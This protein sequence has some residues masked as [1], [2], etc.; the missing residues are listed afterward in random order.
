MR[1][2]GIRLSKILFEIRFRIGIK[3][4]SNF[5]TN[6]IFKNGK[7]LIFE[8]LRQS[9]WVSNLNLMC[10]RMKANLSTHIINLKQFMSTKINA[11]RHECNKYLYRA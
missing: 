3:F 5:E 4:N 1:T 7:Q 6:D 8:R 11:R 9:F 10:I 2:L